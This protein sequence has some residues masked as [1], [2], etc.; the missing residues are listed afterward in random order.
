MGAPA[1]RV[2]T[3]CSSASLRAARAAVRALGRTAP[4]AGLATS[5][6]TRLEQ[7]VAP[8]PC[9]WTRGA[10]LPRTFAGIC[11]SRAAPQRGRRLP[12]A[13]QTAWQRRSGWRC[14]APLWRAYTARASL[15]LRLHSSRMQCQVYSKPEDTVWRH[16][17]RGWVVEL[18]TRAL[19]VQQIVP[20]IQTMTCCLGRMCSHWITVLRSH[21]PFLTRPHP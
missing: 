16:G 17:R 7:P 19:Y 21:A 4:A 11:C 8:S 13:P 12:A 10:L 14:A 6:R 9:S 5:A 1:T 3:C 15:L 18:A 20:G 2:L